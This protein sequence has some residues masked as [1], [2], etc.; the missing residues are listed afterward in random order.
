MNYPKIC[1]FTGH[2]HISYENTAI[3][4]QKLR[5]LIRTL[6]EDGVTTFRAGGA[7]GFDTLAALCVLEQREALGL[8]LELIFPC[9]N[10]TRGWSERDINYYNHILKSCDSYR[11]IS[12]V[13]TDGC[14]LERNRHLVNGS[15]VCV[16]YLTQNRG[17]TLFTVNY[18]RKN[19][20]RVINLAEED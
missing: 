3:L 13:Y 14:M 1:C 18:A 6:A 19:G 20:V 7:M 9:R 8:R 2:R 10:Q 5:R 15:D 17:G 12:D 11:Y 16:A 4:T